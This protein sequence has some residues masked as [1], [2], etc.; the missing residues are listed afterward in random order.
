MIAIAILWMETSG[1]IVLFICPA[2]LSLVCDLPF[3]SSHP[4]S[5]FHA[6]PINLS[7][8]LS[9]VKLYISI[10]QLSLY[11]TT[12]KMQ[13]E[14]KP[15]SSKSASCHKQFQAYDQPGVDC[16]H[17]TKTHPIG[18]TMTRLGGLDL[19]TKLHIQPGNA[20]ALLK[21]IGSN[22]SNLPRRSSGKPIYL[23]PSTF[24]ALP[25]PPFQK[26]KTHGSLN[27]FG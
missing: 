4:C 26:L 20:F 10:L 19:D 24:C 14:N 1:V 23:H 7:M 27:H 3:P 2:I 13:Q 18:P 5:V 17:E 8:R 9:P 12:H 25:A 16:P 6:L 22:G 21:P 11:Q 15:P